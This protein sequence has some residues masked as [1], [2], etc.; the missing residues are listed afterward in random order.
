MPGE[1]QFI[2]RTHSLDLDEYLVFEAHVENTSAI[3]RSLIHNWLAERK[4][5]PSQLNEVDRLR[6]T[7]KQL[8]LKVGELERKARR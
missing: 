2:S 3:L 7:N 4:L 5:L 6:L 1:S 8:L